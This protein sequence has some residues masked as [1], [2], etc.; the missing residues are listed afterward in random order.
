[1]RWFGWLGVGGLLVL[2]DSLLGIWLVLMLGDGLVSLML[3]LGG[4]LEGIMLML[5]GGLLLGEQSG[6]G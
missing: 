2:I 6:C 5:W 3:M 4:G 1:M